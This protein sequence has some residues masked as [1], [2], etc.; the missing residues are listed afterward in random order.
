MTGDDRLDRL[1]RVGLGP[2]RLVGHG[3]G[4]LEPPTSVDPELDELLDERLGR[5][6]LVLA[7][8]RRGE[9]ARSSAAVSL[10]VP[11][12]RIALLTLPLG[13]PGPEDSHRAGDAILPRPPRSHVDRRLDGALT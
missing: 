9:C 7:G 11:N 8:P 12:I 6:T 5:S 1:L 10:P 4:G 13:R 2:Q 3:L